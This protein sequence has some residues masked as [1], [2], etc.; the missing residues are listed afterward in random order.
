MLKSCGQ[1]R[2]T[3]PNLSVRYHAG[4]SDDFLDTRVQV[5]RYGFGMPA[6]NNDE[7]VVPEF[8]KLGVE[9]Q[10]AYGHRHPPFYGL[11]A[12]SAG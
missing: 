12:A 10:D 11:I 6:F 7:I 3:Q 5:I 2:S 1:L 4:I 9:P 8:L